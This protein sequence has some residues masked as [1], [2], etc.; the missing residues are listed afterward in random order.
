MNN[1]LQQAV[2]VDGLPA[3]LEVLW[4][5]ND[6]ICLIRISQLSRAATDA[7]WAQSD[8]YVQHCRHHLQCLKMIYMVENATISPYAR[9]VGEH[10]IQRYGDMTGHIALVFNRR[11]PLMLVMKQFMSRDMA[12][13]LPHVVFTECS[14]E[15]DA[16]AWISQQ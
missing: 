13:H 16:L 7:I 12:H 15:S 11:N 10:Y 3:G 2:I 8:R 6:Q 5:D 9:E 14:T 4:L 1:L